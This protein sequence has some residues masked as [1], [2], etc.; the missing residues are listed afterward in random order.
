MSRRCTILFIVVLFERKNMLTL[1]IQAVQVSNSKIFT[2]PGIH[3]TVKSPCYDSWQYTAPFDVFLNKV[4]NLK[5]SNVFGDPQAYDIQLPLHSSCAAN[6]HYLYPQIPGLNIS[7]PIE[8]GRNYI[9]G[10]KT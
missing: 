7:T 9:Y 10:N 2:R 1:I 3:R 4:A 6:S 5:I 8:N